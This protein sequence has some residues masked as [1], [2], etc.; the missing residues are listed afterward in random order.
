MV[1]RFPP[2]FRPMPLCYLNLY[3][4]PAL[5]VR[6]PKECQPGR[7]DP[8]AQK[9]S[10]STSIALADNSADALGAVVWRI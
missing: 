1:A 5:R 3:G 4:G 10:G 9:G 2:K 7:R 8:V 6:L